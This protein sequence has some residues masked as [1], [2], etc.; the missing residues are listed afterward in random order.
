MAQRL[1][2]VQV[3][4]V[5]M[6]E[7]TRQ[8]AEDAVSRE[9]ADNPAL[10]AQEPSA[11]APQLTDDGSP[12]TETAEQMQRADYRDPDDIP[13]Y[14]FSAPGGS[15]RSDDYEEIRELR[16]ANATSGE[17]LLDNLQQQIAER[18]LPE[19]VREVALY[20]IGNLDSNGYL[21]R[22]PASIANDMAFTTDIDPD[23]QTLKMAIET[24]R[25]LDPPGIGAGS[26]QEALLMQLDAMQP[27][28]VQRNAR[29]I[30]ADAFSELA[31]R[32][33]HRIISLLHLSA[34][35]YE[36]AMKLIL[37]L[38]PRP[39]AALG[40]GA[41]E[42]AG[43]VVPDFQVEET[44]DGDLSV[45][46]P[47]SI[48]ALTIESSFAAAVADMERNA[49]A[50]RS[51]ADDSAREFVMTRFNDAR[52]FIAVV[53]QRQQTLMS[54]MTAIVKLQKSYFLSS[55]ESDLKPMGLKDVA[56][57]TGYDLSTVSRA[58]TGKY[59]AVAWGVI[60]VRHLF[61]EGYSR[62]DTS[63]AAGSQGDASG[64]Q[65]IEFSARRVQAAIRKMVDEEDKRHP[66]SDEAIVKSLCNDGL[67]VS[68]RTIAK[69]RDRMNI[70]PSR[71]RKKL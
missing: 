66:L 27:S 10:A 21:T 36:L 53:K 45:S 7:M 34:Q 67:E 31:M 60:P 54:V 49:E 52:D 65:A 69:Y 9:L 4:Y 1:S 3:R 29:R 37:S 19:L 44:D 26:L 38:N 32:H 59:I 46:I 16:F 12:F 22:S 56:A 13:A 63:A 11:P 39:G 28:E 42:R 41:D 14:R 70:P 2:P 68:R 40:N 71:L 20:I 8:E 23:E 17:S 5:R 15:G 24:V 61:S 58:T 64:A 43:A 62:P 6:L 33:S 18:N 35:E 50:R 51:S 25:S 47:G 55:D 57:L 30:V 48:P